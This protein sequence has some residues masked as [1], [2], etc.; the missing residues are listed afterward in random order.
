MGKIFECTLHKKKPIFKR[1]NTKMYISLV[2]KEN[3]TAML[4]QSPPMK[5][6]K[7]KN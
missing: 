4:Q 3:K 2:I 1:P 7:I 6:A 5:I